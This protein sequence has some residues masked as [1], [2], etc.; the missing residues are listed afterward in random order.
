M[1]LIM[2]D[3]S[4]LTALHEQWHMVYLSGRL[5]YRSGPRTLVTNIA[6]LLHVSPPDMVLHFAPANQ[7]RT[8]KASVALVWASSS[9]SRD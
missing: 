4:K 2:Y 9:I 5:F 7:G 6:V 8:S 3:V 1:Y